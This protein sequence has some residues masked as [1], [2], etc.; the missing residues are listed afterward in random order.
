MSYQI[1]FLD[2][3]DSQVDDFDARLLKDRVMRRLRLWTGV[4][5]DIIADLRTERAATYEQLMLLESDVEAGADPVVLLERI[6][7]LKGMVSCIL[8]ALLIHATF[9]ATDDFRTR[10]RGRDARR[11]DETYLSI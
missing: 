5:K 9:F 7:K 3:L 6:G 10:T 11:K 4:L 2:E 1:T 8:M